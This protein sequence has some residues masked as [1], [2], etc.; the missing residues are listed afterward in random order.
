MKKRR[1]SVDQ[2]EVIRYITNGLI[3]TGIHFG[4]LTFNIQVVGMRSAG[5]A[6][7][8]AAAFGISASF[9]GSRY[10]V[11]KKHQD[12]FLGQATGFLVLYASIAALHGLVL[13]VWTD[14]YGFDYR[15]GFVIVIPIQVALSYWGNKTLVFK[16]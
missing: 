12:P 3:A 14:V 5:V 2:P 7:L 8:I 16:T 10:F 4:V 15:I 1:N 9:L 11:F 6:N 13:Y